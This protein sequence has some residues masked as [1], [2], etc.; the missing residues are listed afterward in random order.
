MKCSAMKKDGSGQCS[1]EAMLGSA[2]CYRHDPSEETAERRRE[3]DRRGGRGGR[4]ETPPAPVEP[5]PLTNEQEVAAMLAATINEVRAG[6]IDSK[7]ANTIG[8][9][10]GHLLNALGDEGIRREL[11][12]LQR[13]VDTMARGN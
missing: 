12:E 1:A 6:T 2:F 5:M 8:I 9:L 3:S 7:R 13:F 4:P 10:S 11:E